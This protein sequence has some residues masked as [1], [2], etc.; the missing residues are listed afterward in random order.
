[1]REWKASLRAFHDR[2]EDPDKPDPHFPGS[3]LS[4]TTWI[5]GF[6]AELRGIRPL[7]A[8]SRLLSG[9][10]PASPFTLVPRYS[11][12]SRYSRYSRIPGVPVSAVPLEFPYCFSN[13][14]ARSAL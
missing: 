4:N 12:C 3:G 11:R 9:Q 8:K 13:G 6:A 10:K 1:M 5:S 2:R 7:L 14:S